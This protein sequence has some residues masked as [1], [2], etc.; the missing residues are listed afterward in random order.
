M[1]TNIKKHFES[2]AMAGY[3]WLPLDTKI[4]ISAEHV[5]RIMKV[6]PEACTSLSSFFVFSVSKT[7]LNT[8]VAYLCAPVFQ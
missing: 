4:V 3:L 5:N 1:Q 2:I 8:F 7:R 6:S